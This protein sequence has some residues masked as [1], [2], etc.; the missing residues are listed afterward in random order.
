MASKPP[1]SPKKELKP[2]RG[3][4]HQR[5]KALENKIFAA[6]KEQPGS[7]QAKSTNY[8]RIK[9][10]HTLVT[11]TNVWTDKPDPKIVTKPNN[12]TAVQYQ[13]ALK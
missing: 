13:E 5:I 2:A 11:S 10:E 12:V 1:T 4:M 9:Y 8:Q 3:N 7:E 6:V